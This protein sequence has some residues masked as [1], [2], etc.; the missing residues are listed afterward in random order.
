MIKENRVSKYLLYAIGEIVLVVIGILIALQINN[1]NEVRKEGEQRQQLISS[2]LEDFEYNRETLLNHKL[3]AMDMAM[4][5][6]EL[7]FHLM[8]EDTDLNKG[9]LLSSAQVSVDSLRKLAIPFFQS[10]PFSANLTTL[11]E[12]SSSGKLSL[13]KNKELFREFTQFEMY[14]DRFLYLTEESTHAYFNGCL[15]EIRRTVDTRCSCRKKIHAKP[16][17]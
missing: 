17:L 3:P 13:L 1:W 2:L 6:M 4:E 11:S 9:Q 8:Q 15:W 12:A 5:K 16:Q 7:F 10:E 14:Y